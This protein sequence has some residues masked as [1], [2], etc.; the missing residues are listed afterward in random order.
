M[1]KVQWRQYTPVLNEIKH[2]KEVLEMQRKREIELQ[3]DCIMNNKKEE[4]NY[5]ADIL[6]LNELIEDCDKLTEAVMEHKMQYLE[7]F[8]N[9]TKRRYREA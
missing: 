3:E 1:G 9:D 6:H 7:Y 2:L 5:N 4:R 8:R